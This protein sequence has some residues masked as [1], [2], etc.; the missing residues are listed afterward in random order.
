MKIVVLDGSAA[1]PGDISWDA[2]AK[3]G[4]LTVYDVT[5]QNQ[6]IERMGDAEI[7][8]TNKTAFSKE[9]IAKL[10]NLKYI[11]VLA[12]GFNVVDL[13]ACSERGIVVTN[14]PQYSTFATMQH[15]IALLLSMT[16]LVESHND[17]VK[18]GDW[19][20]SSQ[21]CFWNQPLTELWNKTLVV[22]GY[23]KI[24][25]QVSKVA[26]ALGMN[27][28]AVPHKMPQEET[29]GIA[30][31]MSFEEALP[32][33]DFITF[34]CPLTEETNQIVNSKTISKMKDGVSIINAARG[35]LINEADMKDAL[36][37]GK[38]KAFAADV[39]SIEPMLP[40]NP[41]LNAPNVIL[42]PHIAWAPKETRERLIEI[43][44][45][46]LEGFLSGNIINKV[47]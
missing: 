31:F 46:N 3:F 5:T 1:N 33:G 21:F 28:I 32:L 14:V 12:T 8:I 25:Q 17:S 36:T 19:V 29:D 42:T 39:V 45:E 20:R 13:K 30:R 43:A 7:A 41:L 24:G 10:P 16:N 15:T 26:S 35:G 18:N 47:N 23:G 27:V 44:A 37:S 11:G 38:V 34:H 6:L 40:D 2:I 9:T 22:F 4:E